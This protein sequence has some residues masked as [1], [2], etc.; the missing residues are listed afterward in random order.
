M[1]VI[2]ALLALAIILLVAFLIHYLGKRGDHSTLLLQKEIDHLRQSHETTN[3]QVSDQLHQ[4]TGEIG[5]RLEESL[6]HFQDANRTVGERLDNAARV[7]G[8]VQNRL[9]K[10]EVATQ[11]VHA[12]GR[13]IATL[14]ET[15]RAPK[16]RGGFGEFIL[17]DLLAQILPRESF[18]LQ[19][20]F[21]SGERVDAVIHT[22]EGMIPVDSKFPYANFKKMVEA[23]TEE[24]KKLGRREFLNDVKKHI[25]DIV[26]YIRPD[27]GTLPFAL[28]Y[29]P[30]ENVYYEA[31]IK[32]DDLEGD[33]LSYCQKKRVFPVSPHSFH[34][35]LQ[36]IAIGFRGMK[37]EEWAR[38]LD[39]NLQR[40][41]E[42]LA[43]FAE[44]FS[45]V[46]GHLKN[47]RQKYESADKRLESFQG[48]F[49]SLE[50][51]D[52]TERL[53]AVPDAP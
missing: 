14:Q 33:L 19:H 26:K 51:P 45:Q 29:I 5:K 12:V 47:L 6:R 1:P 23:K 7:V 44:E 10:L 27:E 32:D 35:Y 50:T 8:E 25:D 39:A 13:E 52:E 38:S 36:T 11:Q 21:R 48:K 49:S 40:L 17:N 24:E 3:R 9:G 37:I 15:L 31:I 30:A 34:A 16:F 2:A 18:E 20:G 28:M 22:Q 53:K 43:R 42:E 4:L 41:K 46:G